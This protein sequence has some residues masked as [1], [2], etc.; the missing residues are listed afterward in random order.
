M[1]YW[2]DKGCLAYGLFLLWLG[3][4]MGVPSLI[5]DSREVVICGGIGISIGMA[6]LS[7]IDQKE[8]NSFRKKMP[9]TYAHFWVFIGY[10]VS[11]I[12]LIGFKDIPYEDM[13]SLGQSLLCYI[14]LPVIA[15]IIENNIKEKKE[16]RFLDSLSKGDIFE[17]DESRE[18]LPMNSYYTNMELIGKSLW[19]IVEI[20]GREIK[21]EDVHYKRRVKKVSVKELM[22]YKREYGVTWYRS[23]IYYESLVKE[24]QKR[25]EVEEYYGEDEE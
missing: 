2:D 8:D 10:A 16:K 3:I 20:S 9:Y 24:I 1:N 18:G 25:A 23:P 5:F 6:V 22:K 4:A 14:P 19:R 13:R 21:L 17:E 12:F 7:L 15:L 11:A